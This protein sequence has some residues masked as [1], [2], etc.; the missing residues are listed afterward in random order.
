[1]ALGQLARLRFRVGAGAVSVTWGEAAFIVGLYLAPSAWLPAATFVGAV[2]AWVLLT[3]FSDRRSPLE[4]LHVAG[5]LTVAVAVGALATRAVGDPFD[6]RLTPTLAGA[7]ALGS[8]AYLLVTGWLAALTLS[9]R[10]ARP[11]G[12]LFLRALRAKLLMFVGN[13]LVGFVVISM[14]ERDLRWLLLL[15]PALWL[16]QQTYGHRLRADEERRLWSAFAAATRE[17]SRLDERAVATA[18]VSGALSIF[19]AE[20]VEVDVIRA[21]GSRRRY[22]GDAS[23]TLAEADV[24]EPLP[25]SLPEEAAG[26]VRLTVAG[27]TVGELRVRF[28]RAL[29][30]AQRE[31]MALA[32]YADAL[33]TALHDAATHQ[34]LK[35]L[36]ERS[37]FEAVHDPLTKLVNRAAFL[38]KGDA[39]MRQVVREV[40]VALLLLDLDR[41][42]DVND[43]LG[44]AAGDELLQSIAVRLGELV[45]PGEL[46]ARFDGDE[47]ALLVTDLEAPDGD[48][49]SPMPQALRR[50]RALVEHL[51]APIEVAGVVMS[52]EASVGVVVA[53]AGSADVAELVRRAENAM[54]QA[55]EAGDSVAWYDSAKDEASTDRLALLAELRDALTVEDQL[56]LALQPAVDL[57]TG[58]PTGVEALIRWRHPRRGSLSPVD[59]V[60]A[61]EG[62]DL[63]APFTRYVVDKALTVAAEWAGEGLEVPIS[64]NLSARSL[65]DPHLPSDIAEL[66]RRHRVPARRLV[67]EITETVVLSELEVIDE[68]L[69]ALRDLGVQLSVDDFGTGYSS[70]TFLT[71]IPVNEVK[72]DRSFVRSMADAPTSAAIVNATVDLGHR[73]GLRVVAEGVETADQRAALAALGCGAAQGYHFFKPMPADKIVAVLRS[74]LDSAQAQVFPLRADGAS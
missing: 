66:L 31:Q 20:A 18:G 38:I 48:R 50:A 2:L 68:V 71:R 36:T 44:H 8:L 69:G 45:E 19:G 51:A 73:L 37:A 4:I 16:L 9:V 24:R 13:V 26:L 54:Y 27:A 35:A 25:E 30:P 70:F 47:F 52:V 53:P 34:A 17:L 11:A 49:S 21:D 42:K 60:R 40:P 33:A 62:S 29:E 28:P 55:K 15:P 57:D 41:F 56:V 64:V 10:Q 61:V 5:S 59:F 58:A 65:L 14:I 46:L 63:L 67:L 6:A 7:L 3:Y 1:M 22:S 72:I 12:G 43:T 74:L 39:A 32:A 23:G